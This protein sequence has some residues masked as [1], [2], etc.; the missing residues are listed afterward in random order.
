MSDAPKP[1]SKSSFEI[2][3]GTLGLALSEGLEDL[4]VQHWEE[5]E[6]HQDVVPLDVDWP[7]YLMLERVG[8]YKVILAHR[9]GKLVGYASYF[10]Q[11]PLRHKS[12]LWAVNDGLF[13]DRSARRSALG[14]RLIAESERLVGGL[15]VKLI[16]QGDRKV[17]TG[18]STDA[19]PHATLGDLLVRKG[20]TLAERTYAKLL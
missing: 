15:G 11:A 16:S 18:N 13:V 4:M 19:K 5:V 3:W 10:V 7:K 2:G 14:V 17:D 6:Q 12:S 20:Y 9:R 1:P 8:I